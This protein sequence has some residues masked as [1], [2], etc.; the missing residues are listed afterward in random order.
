MAVGGARYLLR[1]RERSECRLDKDKL[2]NASLL[3][4]YNSEKYY[5]CQIDS[6]KDGNLT[7]FEIKSLKFQTFESQ[8][9]MVYFL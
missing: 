4:K 2:Q 9:G 7:S 6:V 1:A 5:R 3:L 8:A